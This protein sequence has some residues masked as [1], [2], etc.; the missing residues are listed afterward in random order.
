M[1]MSRKVSGWLPEPLWRRVKTTMPIPCVDIIVPNSE[2]AVLLGWRVIQPYVNVWATPGGRIRFGEGPVKA[3]RR[4]L[5]YHGLKASSFYLVG[6]FPIMFPS[7]FDISICIATT[8]YSGS[9]IPDGTELT[10]IQW[11]KKLPK[12]TGKNYVEMIKKWRRITTCHQALEINR[13]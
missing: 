8:S 6:V 11:F 12:G 3:A 13:L 10:K 1:R 7:R 5:S 2:G 9:P 4:T